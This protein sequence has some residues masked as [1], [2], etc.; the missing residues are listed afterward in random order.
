MES[1]I[2]ML[3]EFYKIDKKLTKAG[4]NFFVMMSPK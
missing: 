4:S 2:L 1:F 3:E